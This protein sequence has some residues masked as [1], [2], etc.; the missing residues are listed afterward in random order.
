LC[1]AEWA[2]PAIPATPEQT[3]Y[4]TM[5]A[6]KEEEYF[7]LLVGFGEKK[8]GEEKDSTRCREQERPL[9]DHDN[10]PPTYPSPKERRVTSYLS[11]E[12]K[13]EKGE[14]IIASV[15]IKDV[16]QK[17][18]L[19][20]TSFDKE[21]KR[22]HDDLRQ[23]KR[24]G[25]M[26]TYFSCQREILQRMKVSF[27]ISAEREKEKEKREGKG[28]AS[29]WRITLCKRKKELPTGKGRRERPGPL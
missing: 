9:D 28:T 2:S 26:L 6:E 29:L 7:L 22:G 20:R 1:S 24:G 19:C 21:K 17:S 13:G 27:A 12:K 4:I 25:G 10:D 3:P 14:R 15:M 23:R 18:P 16:M 8:G 11:A 5:K